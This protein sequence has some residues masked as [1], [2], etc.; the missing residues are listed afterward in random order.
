MIVK[1]YFDK[2]TTIVQDSPYNFGL[3]PICAINYGRIVSRALIY[4]DEKKIKSLVNDKTFSDMSKLK[5]VLKMKNCGSIDIDRINMPIPSEDKNGLKE[6]ATSFDA[7]LFL[8]PKLWDRGRGFDFGLD[9]WSMGGKPSISRHGCTWYQASDG[10]YWDEEGVYSNTTLALEYDKFSSGEDSL[11]IG[12]QHFD[13]GNENF[14]I[15]ITETVNKFISG[16]I[17]NYGIGIMFS[18]M[19][20]SSD[21]EVTQYVGFFNK[22]TNTIFEPYLETTYDMYISDDRSEFY[23]NK[24]NKLYLYAYTDGSLDNLDNIPTCTI[25]DKK[26]QVKQA[27]KGV[28]YAEILIQNDE[29]ADNTILYDTWSNLAYNGVNLEDVEME[30]VVLSDKKYFSI[31]SNAEEPK[32]LVPYLSG[33]N[34]D[35]KLNQGEK[36][37]IRVDYRRNFTTDKRDLVNKSEYRIYTKEAKREVDVI[38]YQPIEKMNLYNFFTIDTND[39]VP[40]EYFIDVKV[41]YGSEIRLYKEKLRFSVVNN[42]TEM[43][44]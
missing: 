14:E 13:F 1:T 24:M 7:I 39:F 36:R 18:P 4:F 5:H 2:C 33:I 25:N 41:Y 10:N 34:D 37:L 31:G 28:Y 19:L 20:E 6:R 8:I 9:F 22:Y 3:N 23:K 30:F 27:T 29:V 12:R 15:D 11:V 44:R 35:E 40:G 32:T 42:V 38:S 43:R 21:A 17:E 26:Y 16:E